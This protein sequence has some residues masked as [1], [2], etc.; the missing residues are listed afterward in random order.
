MSLNDDDSDESFLGYVDLHSRTERAMFSRGQVIRFLK[1]A[2]V[3]LSRYD[4]PSYQNWFSMRYGSIKE[5][6]ARARR[7]VQRLGN[8]PGQLELP[9]SADG[10]GPWLLQEY[11]G[12]TQ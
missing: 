10:A 12:C 2:R 3:D 11:Q 8:R 4:M 6:L 1:L 9:F 5:E 7:Q